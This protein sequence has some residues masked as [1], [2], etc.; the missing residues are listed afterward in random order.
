M[1]LSVR[2]SAAKF[3]MQMSQVKRKIASARMKLVRTVAMALYASLDVKTLGRLLSTSMR[4][5]M[6]QA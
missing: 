4:S 2:L 1:S 3:A 6:S 5:K